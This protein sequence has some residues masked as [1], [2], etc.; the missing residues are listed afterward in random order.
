MPKVFS[1]IASPGRGDGQHAW[2]TMSG[3]WRWFAKR[4]KGDLVA[5]S[6]CREQATMGIRDAKSEI[7]G[8]G[9]GGHEGVGEWT[10][11][12]QAQRASR[13]SIATRRRRC[14]SS[15]GTRNLGGALVDD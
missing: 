2:Q 12:E 1:C 10:S 5:T 4:A 9:R 15:P 14:G 8:L 6:Q 13:D 7:M 11:Q 3:R